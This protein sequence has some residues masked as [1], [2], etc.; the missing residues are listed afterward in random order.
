[1]K[2]EEFVR[3]LEKFN[4]FKEEDLYLIEK[5]FYFGEKA[6]HG[7]V[8]KSGEA[9]FNHCVRTAL[10]L[11]SLNLDEIVISAGLLHDT[12]EDCGV[13]E[14]ELKNQF[15]S[16]ITS[17]VKGV[18]K[19]GHY[20][21]AEED[22]EQAENLRNLILAISEDLRVAIVKLA[23]RLDNMRTLEYLP[24]EKQMKIALETRDIYA[25]LA[26]RLGIYKWA[27][28]LDELSFKFLDPENY[29]KVINLFEE[30]IK[31]YSSYLPKIIDQ[32]KDQL[33]LKGIKIYQI[34]YRVK[35]YSSIYKKLVKKNFDPNK[36]Y[37][38]FGV[39][40]IV[41]TVEECY[42]TLGIIHSLY[43]PLEEEFDDYIS[44][45]KPNGYR[46]LHTVVLTPYDFFTEF[47]I[48]T[49]EMHHQA[50]YGAAAYF[51]YSESK[52]SKS[53][54]KNISL[55]ANQEDLELIKKIR[56][57]K[58]KDNPQEFLDLLKN[59]FF[60][61]RIYVL[62]PKGKIIELPSGSTPVDFAYKIHTE[63]GHH[64]AGAKVNGNLVPL[65][66]ELKNGD[67]V[68]I[69]VS[70]NKKPSLD[71]LEFVKT[72]S[73]RKKIKAFWRKEKLEYLPKKGF[74]FYFT[75]KDR[76]GLL[77]DI[78]KIFR[79][80][81]INI[82]SHQ[83]KVNGKIANLKIK[84]EVNDPKIVD[85]LLLELKQKIKEIL[86]VRVESLN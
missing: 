44:K 53:Y 68:E 21:Y 57:W 17:I 63:L 13:S 3:E 7:Q 70:K 84:F 76:L 67:V 74:I 43:P 2:W 71:W 55:T 54:L 1:M 45:P 59:E 86:D 5:A 40:I 26:N 10:N 8:R 50:E 79:K 27:G 34:D 38:L 16:E 73:A 12:L 41:E 28:E 25:P 14:E 61:E 75:L 77:D 42:I 72:S 85:E 32:V 11:A 56:E 4:K 15:G 30:K 69:I 51:V 6:H 66:Y 39:R 78:L 29:Q 65:N 31:H 82:L 48:R 83:G 20:R 49:L 35:T 22:I 47:Q 81:K 58:V 52:T 24:K 37:D 18:T 46:S 62:T 9:Y 33:K 36:I 80:R 60:K 23:D 64:C 19:I